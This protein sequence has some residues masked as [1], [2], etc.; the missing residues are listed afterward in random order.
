[1]TEVDMDCKT[2]RV[3]GV[4]VSKRWLDVACEGIT[5]VAR[6]ANTPAELAGFVQK[7][8]AGDVVVFE[9]SGGYERSLE[10]ALAEAGIAFSLVHSLRV[11][12]FREARAIKAK[13]DA[14]DARLLMAFGRDRLEAGALRLGRLEDVTFATLMTRRNQLAAMLHAERCRL[15]TM[16]VEVV[17]ASLGRLID[18]LADE[19]ATIE[20]ALCALEAA[21]PLL[22]RKQQVL[23]ETIGV[24][25]QTARALLAE[26]PELGQLDRKEI[27]ALGGLAPRVHQSGTTRYRRGLAPGRTAIKVILF[28]PARSAMHRDPEIGAFCAELRRRGKPGKVVMV[29]VMRKMLVRLNARLRDALAKNQSRQGA[30]RAA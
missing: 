10:V 9:R 20:S 7:L 29:A 24:A 25:K 3:I 16:E 17:R 30:L 12:S 5:K 21:D 4:D 11:K 8:G 1:M 22:A 23:I 27:T 6:V 15:E 13:T 2:M 28:N 26:L 19:L 18:Y 14:I